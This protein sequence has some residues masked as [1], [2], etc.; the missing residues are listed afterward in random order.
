MEEGQAPFSARRAR[1][2]R[3]AWWIAST[4][5]IKSQRS[6]LSQCSDSVSKLLPGELF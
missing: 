6:Q 1:R 4:Y 3:K 2:T 5:L